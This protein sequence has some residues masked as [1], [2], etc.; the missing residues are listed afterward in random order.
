MEKKQKLEWFGDEDRK[1]LIP[2]LISFVPVDV[3][4]GCVASYLCPRYR[5][6]SPTQPCDLYKKRYNDV[7]GEMDVATDEYGEGDEKRLPFWFTCLVG[8]K[9]EFIFEVK[10]PEA[11]DGGWSGQ[12]V[13][14]N[15]NVPSLQR[16]TRFEITNYA[17][18]HSDSWKHWTGIAWSNID[19]HKKAG[20]LQYKHVIFEK[21]GSVKGS[22]TNVSIR[23]CILPN[24]RSI[25]GPDCP[26]A[27]I[28]GITTTNE[29]VCVYNVLHGEDDERGSRD[30]RDNDSLTVTLQEDGVLA[31]LV[32]ERRACLNH[33]LLVLDTS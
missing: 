20:R 18:Y 19:T 31:D 5:L 25:Q 15:V 17:G 16:V 33:E 22:E 30:R 9:E 7:I 12:F 26:S 29:F 24:L 10:Q 3:L 2:Y 23:C 32:C 11:D 28:I 4:A 27:R 13:S 1:I 6:V 14:Y 21:E 8:Q